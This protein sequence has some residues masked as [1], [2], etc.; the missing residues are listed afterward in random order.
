VSREPARYIVC[1]SV[2]LLAFVFKSPAAAA[3]AKAQAPAAP[4]VK[5]AEKPLL[6]GRD[7]GAVA[8]DLEASIPGLL[9]KGHVPGLQIA[10]IRDGKI[11]WHGAFG[12]KNAT[13]REPVT[14]ETIFEAASLTKPFFAYFAMKLVDEGVLNLDTPLVQYVPRE[15]IEKAIGHSL[16][17]EGFRRDWFEKIT[18]RHVLSHSSGLPHGEGGAPFPIFFEPGTKYKYSA[19]GY[20][21]LQMAI[22]QLKGQKLDVLMKEY[23]LDP[24]GM[25]RSAMV[26][27]DA[28][29]KTMANGHGA[30][31]TPEEFRKRTEAHAAATLYTT[32]SDYAR[33]VCAVLNDEGLKKKTW[34]E[35]L[36]PQIVVDKDKGLDWSLGFALQTD[37]NGTAIWQWG[38]YG[39]FRNYVIAY[40][41]QKT[42]VVYFANSFYGLDICREL[43]PRSIGGEARGVE[44]LEYLPY[45]SPIY[46]FLWAIMEKG[47][48]AVDELLPA[49]AAEHPEVISDKAIETTLYLLK[50]GQRYDEVMAYCRFLVEKRPSSAGLYA[51]LAEAYLQKD[52]FADA[53][54]YYAKA[55]E[56][57][58]KE[59]FD[60]TS[61]DWAMTYMKVLEKPATVPADH[62]QKLAGDYGQRHI[63][64]ENGK[65]YYFRENV[66]AKDYRELIPLSE[67]T[68]VIRGLSYFRMRF[69]TDASGKP[70]KIIG[71]YVGGQTDQSVRD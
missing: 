55:L 56:A 17:L 41:K 32:A 22:E 12:V 2:L 9:E 28:Y 7:A 50:E 67:D 54:A 64:F 40:P 31:G 69:E 68:F 27:Q 25:T 49:V 61:V 18:A 23:V 5:A 43:V 8:A 11:V 34:K 29:E 63:K 59:H 58:D 47:P 60:S 19:D 38:D 36:T 20:Y 26:W 39:I 53:K 51:E 48:A 16:D 10:L 65:L 4:T 37:A 33:F 24:L 70:T 1:L 62:M 35:M 44:F 42:G 30:Y 66:A 13:T 6:L 45:D 46:A 15:A 57:P 14:D 52:D 21:F 3:E 71:M